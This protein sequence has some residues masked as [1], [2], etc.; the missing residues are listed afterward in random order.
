M[1]EQPV[2]Q[3]IDIRVGKLVLQK[4]G[5]YNP[6]YR[7]PY[8]IHASGEQISNIVDLI[9]AHGTARIDGG[10]LTGVVG[11]ILAPAAEAGDMIYIPN[12][13]NEHR[14]R[15]FLE[16]HCRFTFS[17]VIYYIQGYTNFDGITETAISPDLVFIINSVTSSVKTATMT[18]TGMQVSEVPKETYQ[19]IGDADNYSSNYDTKYLM[20]PHD[21]FTG[22]QTEYI[23]NASDISQYSTVIDNRNIVKQSN[24]ARSSRHY[25]LPAQYVASI[26]D[27][28]AQ[29]TA[30]LDI[31][32]TTQDALS[33]ARERSLDPLL[34]QN[35]FFR[36]ISD[37]K[38]NGAVNTFT[39][40]DLVSIDGNTPA[41]TNISVIPTVQRAALHQAG[42]SAFWHGSD[43]ITQVANILS[44]AVPAIMM[45][46]LIS[47]I[48]FRTTNYDSTGLINTTIILCKSLSTNSN[49]PGMELFKGRLAQDVLLDISFGNQ[50]SFMIEMSVDMF[51]ET[52]I[53]ITMYGENARFVTP[54]FCDNLTTPVLSST[55]NQFMGLVSGFDT[56][57][58]EVSSSLI[59]ARD[60]VA[61]PIRL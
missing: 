34:G 17:D 54:S 13:W 2:N 53:D 61:R 36:K 5:T 24:P 43:R 44:Q 30:M 49:V 48:H 23:R 7:R 33:R 19:V 32:H 31:G 8:Q 45:E 4:T 11:N 15:F 22:I 18:P 37:F 56:L 9:S 58:N 60:S 41:V 6:Q 57:I 55:E 12:G 3:C 28:Y 27:K 50:D 59:E 21:I 25:G 46:V 26:V 52:I 40:S 51:G 1:M 47:K 39:Y 10:L 29:A 14:V 16:V 35:P 38:G 20:R 42:Q